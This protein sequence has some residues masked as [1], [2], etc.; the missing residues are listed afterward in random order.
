[1]GLLEVMFLVFMTLK[2]IGVI[3]WSWLVVCI[4]LIVSAVLY[5][6]AIILHIVVA[7]K[8]G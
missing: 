6:I 7:I 5:I 1:M 3:S 8:E 4:P 2:L